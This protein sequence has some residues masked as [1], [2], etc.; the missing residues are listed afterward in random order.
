M[1]D[2]QNFDKKVTS[3]LTA[4]VN[5]KVV[6]DFVYHKLISDV[7]FR[8]IYLG[9][10]LFQKGD[11]FYTPILDCGKSKGD[12]WWGM[13]VNWNFGTT[14]YPLP[15]NVPDDKLESKSWY[16]YWKKAKEKSGG[17]DPSMTQNMFLNSFSISRP[18]NKRVIIVT[19]NENWE[20]SVK[21]QGDGIEPKEVI[22]KEYTAQD[23]FFSKPKEIEIKAGDKIGYYFLKNGNTVFSSREVLEISIIHGV[24]GQ[25]I[26]MRL[27]G[28]PELTRFPGDKIVVFPK[29]DAEE[30]RATLKLGKGDI[31]LDMKIDNVLS[32]TSPKLTISIKGYIKD[33]SIK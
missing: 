6:R 7:E 23:I 22:T 26:K 29:K 8:S 25:G 16:N 31:G 24:N 14:F 27:V 17:Y 32:R 30:I 20:E 28:K 2:K 12:G 9:K 33:A 11:N 21:M 4:L 5:G 18:F 19:E 3:A 10:I 1:T 15:E 13:L